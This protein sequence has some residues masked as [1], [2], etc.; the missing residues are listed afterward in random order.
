MNCAGCS[1]GCPRRPVQE[2]E[3]TGKS[4]LEY[5]NQAKRLFK[6]S[7]TPVQADAPSSPDLTFFHYMIEQQTCFWRCVTAISARRLRSFQEDIAGSYS[8]YSHKINTATRPTYYFIEF[9]PTSEKLRILRG[10]RVGGTWLSWTLKLQD[11]Q[12]ITGP[13]HRGRSSGAI[14]SELENKSANLT[15]MCFGNTK[16]TQETLNA[17]SWHVNSR[18]VWWSLLLVLFLYFWIF[19][20]QPLC[21]F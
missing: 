17:T 2:D 21:L 3:Q 7:Q 9:W 15:E 4:I 16:R 11:V 20:K 13:E 14:L 8:Q 5:Q 1:T 19:L 10:S 6:T 12:R 18:C